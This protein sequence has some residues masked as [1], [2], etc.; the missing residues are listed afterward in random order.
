MKPLKSGKLSGWYRAKKTKKRQNQGQWQSKTSSLQALYFMGPREAD[1][2]LSDK[3]T[4]KRRRSFLILISAPLSTSFESRG[5]LCSS[6]H[7]LD[8]CP[9]F[10]Q[11]AQHL[12][13]HNE[14]NES[15]KC[16]AVSSRASYVCS[17]P[18]PS[19]SRRLSNDERS[20]SI[21]TVG[22]GPN[23]SPAS[24]HCP[25]KGGAGKQ[26]TRQQEV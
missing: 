4:T 14:H 2:P 20:S 23:L 24:P 12:T 19:S 18:W 15:S 3:R 6:M 13:V 22:M 17:A 8:L 5:C 11:R 21:A 7:L 26:H 16:S 9:A 1:V 25:P 10:R